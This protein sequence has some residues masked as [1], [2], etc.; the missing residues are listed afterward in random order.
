MSALSVTLSVSGDLVVRSKDITVQIPLDA[1]YNYSPNTVINGFELISAE[2]VA[3]LLQISIESSITPPEAV[4]PPL[5]RDLLGFNKYSAV[6]KLAESYIWNA[7]GL[8]EF[9]RTTFAELLRAILPSHLLVQ[10]EGTFWSFSNAARNPT[11]AVHL[12][13]T[14]PLGTNAGSG[15]RPDV[16][17]ISFPPNAVRPLLPIIVENKKAISRKD[18]AD[19]IGWPCTLRGRRTFIDSLQ[20]AIQQVEGQAALLF[21]FDS[22]DV[23]TRQSDVLLIAAVGPLYVVARVYR[24]ELEAAYRFK[25]PDAIQETID[26]LN[27][28]ELRA[29]E[30]E[31]QE[32]IPGPVDEMVAESDSYQTSE[33]TT[34]S[35]VKGS[36][37]SPY[38]LDTLRSYRLLHK[39]VISPISNQ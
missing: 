37:S 30:D 7:R 19:G 5:F 38:L 33:Y 8:E 24:E 39:M 18:S 31:A 6:K 22:A 25:T 34:F 14:M 4:L 21:K 3:K 17:V 1:I 28:E 10:E 23:E 13:R 29:R 20:R 27:Q 2:G 35:A 36:W 26:I 32:E 16:R 15:K 11:P 12:D 9:W